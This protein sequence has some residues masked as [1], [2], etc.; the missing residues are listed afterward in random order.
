MLEPRF[1]V[2]G[3]VGGNKFKLTPKS[4]DV[5]ERDGVIVGSRKSIWSH[6]E[7]GS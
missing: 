7:C 1:E 6:G 3:M 4:V 2:K 5:K